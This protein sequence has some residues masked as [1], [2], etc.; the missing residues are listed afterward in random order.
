MRRVKALSG[1]V[2]HMSDPPLSQDSPRL[3]SHP[4]E[5]AMHK[6]YSVSIESYLLVSIVSMLIRVLGPATRESSNSI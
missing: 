3:S 1:T 2:Q 5:A 4:V 6:D